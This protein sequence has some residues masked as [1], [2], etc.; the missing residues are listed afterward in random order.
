VFVEKLGKKNIFYLSYFFLAI[1]SFMY[2]SRWSFEISVF[3]IRFFLAVINTV[4]YPLINEIYKSS[5]RV[6]ITSFNYGSS[7]IFSSGFIL[8]CGSIY[9]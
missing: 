3:L 5:L 4:Q 2:Y 8:I 7:Q 1:F 9:R 6:A